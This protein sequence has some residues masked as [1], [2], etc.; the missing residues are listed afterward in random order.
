MATA[1]L[2]VSAQ[3]RR[4]Q[5]LAAATELFARQGFQGTTTRQIAA[6][7]GINEAIIFRH[8]P[9]KEELYWAIMDAKSRAGGGLQRLQESLRSGRDDVEVFA[10]LA[11]K[12]LRR[13]S[14]M[15]R[16]LLFSA[17]ENH[18]LSQR[19]FRAHVAQY[20]EALAEHIRA[21][22]AAGRFRA[23]DPL[24]AARGFL[25]MVFYH[26]MIQELFGGKRFQQFDP[27][28]VG[29]TLAEI[30]M[31]G[32]LPPGGNHA[33]RGSSRPSKAG[34]NGNQSETQSP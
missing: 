32:M 1:H 33:F 10:A 12:M 27:A 28:A 19:F 15:T 13:D 34:K 3:D 7:A 29:R 26:F 16:L 4:Q 21:G 6:R 14:T 5:I 18:R 30:F 31:E 2:R 17:L 20:Y 23:V 9:T 22:I 24:L 25:G 8:F 11:E